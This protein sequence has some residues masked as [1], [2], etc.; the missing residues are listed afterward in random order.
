MA[1]QK[2]S[3]DEIRKIATQRVRRRI[4]FYWHLTTYLLV[5]LMLVAIWYFSG[6]GYFWPVWVMLFW[7]IGLAFNA[8]AV[9]LRRDFDWERRQIEKEME[10][11]KKDRG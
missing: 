6:A 9:F 10:K 11:I 3:E 5:N 1:S 7:G 8:V 4:G 2:M